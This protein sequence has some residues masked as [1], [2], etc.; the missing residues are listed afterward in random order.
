[1]IVKRSEYELREA[2]ARAHILEGYLIALDHIDDIIETIKKSKDEPTAKASLVK[3]FGLTEIQAQ[4]ILD[5]QLRRLAALERKKIEEEHKQI[6]K[7]IEEME[8][9]LG[10]PANIIK[11]VRTEL[12]ELKEKHA[13]ARRTKVY[14]GKADDIA[15]EDMVA[16]E[17]TFVTLSYSGY[18]KRMPPTTYKVQKRGGKGVVGQTTKE[19]DYIEHAIT[20]N[21]HDNIVFFTNKGRAFETKA[22]E[23]PEF[24]RTAKGIPAVNLVQMEQGERITAVLSR[25]KKGITMDSDQTQEDENLT[26]EIQESKKKEKD[27]PA[28]V[29]KYLFMAT[30][31]GTV[32]KTELTDFDKIRSS[33]LISVK[34][35]PGDELKWVR[36]STG[37]DEVILVTRMGKSI[38]FHEKDVRP[39]GR[40]T[41]GVTGIRFKADQDELISMDIVRKEENLLLTISEKGYGKMTKLKEYPLQGRA[42]QGVFTFRVN[43]K[44]GPLMIARLLDHPDRELVIISRHGQVIRS[45]IKQIAQL[46]RHTSG[47]RTMKLNDG[48]TVAAMAL[49]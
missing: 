19:D 21:T 8:A 22:F 32:K 3:K 17:E 6:L 38:R 7:F 35:D 11:Q 49:M 12:E 26:T 4:A 44:T 41:R 29:Y 24:S 42:G 48:D 15:E 2:K 14:K 28:K 33:G 43:D 5:M 10:D 36:P 40:A 20:C 13:D 37:K 47:V 25:G 30:K 31:H 39:T 9:L 16:S 27:E 1:M 18:I 34:L 46:G 45:E 23:I